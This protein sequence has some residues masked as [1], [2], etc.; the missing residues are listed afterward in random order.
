MPSSPLIHLLNRS[1]LSTQADLAVIAGDLEGQDLLGRLKVMATDLFYWKSHDLVVNTDAMYGG[2]ARK[3][4]YFYFDRGAEVNHFQYFRNH[5]TRDLLVNW[6]TQPEG[7]QA[8]TGFEELQ[9]GA[10]TPLR[11]GESRGAENA[12]IVLLVGDLMTT[13]LHDSQGRVWLDFDAL[14]RGGLDRI[15]ADAPHVSTGDVIG[16]VY[17]QLVTYLSGRFDV[18][19]FPYDWRQSSE[20]EGTRLA[21]ELGKLLATKRVVHLV[22]HGFGGLLVESALAPGSTIEQQFKKAG[23]RIVSLGAPFAGQEFPEK[24]CQ[25]LTMM[26]LGRDSAEIEALMKAWPSLQE[27]LPANRPAKRRELPNLI[28]V[29]GT[30]ALTPGGDGR[31]THA[32]A[33]GAIDYYIEAAH[34]DLLNYRPAFPAITELID[35]GRTARLR[36]TPV[37]VPAARRVRL[38]WCCSPISR[39]CL[40]Q[41]LDRSD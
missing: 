34:G 17:Q 9:R 37:D 5:R 16:D 12:P 24:L 1:D 41:P 35:A 36:T 20:K 22:A 4:A 39:I 19:L 40:P 8:D 11:K 30:T 38:R 33:G 3:K 7:K 25:L 29:A 6:L 15:A 13:H 31:V 18:V 32:E 2:L 14:M 23:G 26:D 10:V 27:T 21:D 28:Y